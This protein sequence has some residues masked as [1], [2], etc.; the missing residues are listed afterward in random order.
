[1]EDVLAR[2]TRMLVLNPRA[3]MEAAPMV[4]SRLAGALDRDV[5]WEKIQVDSFRKLAQGY[6]WK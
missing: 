3:A 1:M 5:V 4:A 2:R 6:I